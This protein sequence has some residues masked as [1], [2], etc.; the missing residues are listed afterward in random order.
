MVVESK[1]TDD[2]AAAL[3]MLITAPIPLQLS[4]LTVSHSVKACE[5][6]YTV[7]VPRQQFNK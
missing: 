1:V 5:M 2:A 3:L 7:N 6:L 4:S